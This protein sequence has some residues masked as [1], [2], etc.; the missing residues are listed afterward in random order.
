MVDARIELDLEGLGQERGRFVV[1]GDRDLQGRLDPV[2]GDLLG[3]PRPVGDVRLVDEL[4][5]ALDEL[6]GLAAGD[7]PVEAAGQH[8]E[9]DKKQDSEPSHGVYLTV[10]R[11]A[12]LSRR[13]YRG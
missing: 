3:P 2:V 11:K 13:F 5:R 4:D 6:S 7:L 9:P 10:R 8:R 12:S 1:L